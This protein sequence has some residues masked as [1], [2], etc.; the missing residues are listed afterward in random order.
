MRLEMR[1]IDLKG[2]FTNRKSPIANPVLAP[3]PKF[4]A[5]A[6]QKQ[7]PTLITQENSI[8]FK[9]TNS[10][11]LK[12]KTSNSMFN[13][14]GLFL[15]ICVILNFTA[16]GQQEVDSFE[17][18]RRADEMYFYVS[19]ALDASYEQ[20]DCAL[21]FAEKTLEL[22][23]KY[24]RPQYKAFGLECKGLYH[25]VVRNDYDSASFYFFKA[26]DLCENNELTYATTLYH[27]VGSM[28]HRLD[29]YEKA[30][31]YYK[32]SLERA[33][34]ENDLE[35][36]KQSVGNLGSICS[37]LGRYQE[38][39]ELFQQCF[40]IEGSP[41]VGFGC[42]ANLGNMYIRQE[43][44]EE[45]IEPLIN[46]TLEDPDNFLADGNIRFLLDAKTALSDTSGM[47]TYLSRAE[48]YLEGRTEHRNTRL[49]CES[50]S[51]YYA[52]S[53]DYKKAL[54][55][56]KKHSKISAE[57]LELQNEEAVLSVEAEYQTEKILDE[58]AHKESIQQ[59]YCIFAAVAGFLILILGVLFIRNR[60]AN[61]A[62]TVQK[63]LLESTVDEKN[64]LLKETH[65]R[66]KNSFQMVSSLLYLQSENAQEEDAKIAI[67]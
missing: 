31:E 46:A 3:H 51:A 55:F 66:I 6:K 26:I 9:P 59:S 36:W 17:N 35:I 67:K 52:M 23:K 5:I 1:I 38:A 29:N 22:A 27:T 43:K 49:M 47:T 11:S 4:I 12:L 44:Y 58:L 37:S 33:K 19:E 65:L 25:E 50:L 14:T 32:I 45:A 48:T 61:K 24:E 63:T 20:S 30:E 34:R 54:E 8:N 18:E 53:G 42:Y 16:V 39:E 7:L 21:F 2:N 41:G 64:I 62:L 28:F 40:E 10:S 13:R 60:R 57:M 56:E 15:F